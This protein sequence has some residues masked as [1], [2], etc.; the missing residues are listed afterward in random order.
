MA[1]ECPAECC[2]IGLTRT[3]NL[4]PKRD[5]K[6][7]CSCKTSPQPLTREALVPVIHDDGNGMPEQNVKKSQ[8]A[9]SPKRLGR[10]RRLSL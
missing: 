2:R 1:S 7:I 6:P 9:Q 10:R 5:L 4:H 3:P 8:R